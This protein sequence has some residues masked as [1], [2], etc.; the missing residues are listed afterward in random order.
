MNLLQTQHFSLSGTDSSLLEQSSL[1]FKVLRYLETPEVP[2]VGL[3]G[4]DFLLGKDL[5]DFT[6]G[7][8]DI[9]DLGFFF[10]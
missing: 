7:D 2:W 10:Y 5:E 8:L 4:F 6:F 1:T 9:V 3:H